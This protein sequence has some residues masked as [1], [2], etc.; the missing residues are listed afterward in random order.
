MVGPLLDEV[1]ATG[2]HV[3][4]EQMD[5]NKWWIGI[6][7]GGKDCRETMRIFGGVRVIE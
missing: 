2:A 1:V 5:R 4:L 6:Q 3:H 7:S